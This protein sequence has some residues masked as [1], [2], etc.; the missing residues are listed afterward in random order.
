MICMQN[1]LLVHVGFDDHA[2]SIEQLGIDSRADRCSL[3][4]ASGQDLSTM[5][6]VPTLTLI[7]RTVA[8]LR[9][10]VSVD[11]VLPD[12]SRIVVWLT[13]LASGTVRRCRRRVTRTSGA[14]TTG[15]TSSTSGRTP[16][17]T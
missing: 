13:Y 12:A 7:T 11:D 1:D 10:A 4:T 8:D 6:S 14:E 2:H 17:S 15:S 9:R 16:G 5:D 3:E